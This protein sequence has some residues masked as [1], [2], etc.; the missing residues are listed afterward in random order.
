[1]V[2]T[3]HASRMLP[4]AAPTRMAIRSPSPVLVGRWPGWS[5]GRA[6]RRGPARRPTR[7]HRWRA[8]R[9]GGPPT[10]DR[11]VGAV[12]G[13][14]ATRPS[15]TTS[16][17]ARAPS[18][19][20]DAPVQAGLEQRADEGLPTAPDVSRRP[21][22]EHLGGDGAVAA[23]ERRLGQR[24]AGGCGRVGRPGRPTR[25]GPRSSTGR[26]RG[27]APRPA[28]RQGAPG[29]SR[30]SPARPRTAPACWPPATPRPRAR[31]R[32]APR[33]A[34]GRSCRATASRGRRGRPRGC[35]RC[36]SARMCGLSG[37]QQSPP[38]IAVVPPTTSPFSNSADGGARRRRPARPPTPRLRAQHH[39]VGVHGSLLGRAAGPRRAC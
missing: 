30:G 26:G 29:G 38:E 34:R 17:T 24:E 18:D 2:G 20:L 37:T 9:R 31:C 10:S 15:S 5:S 36:R 13:H 11:A 14:A 4:S 21:V 12:E 39:H 1:M 19:R 8:P 25:R 28:S 7:S 16:S 33:R 27:S 6:G 35:R 32:P 23:T 3:H 22:G